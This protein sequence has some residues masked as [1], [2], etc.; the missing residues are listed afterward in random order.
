MGT[1]S[2]TE[3]E[4]REGSGGGLRRE[5][6]WQSVKGRDSGLGKCGMIVIKHSWP[7]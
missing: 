5:E 1:R 4:D 7:A 3:S 6:K 2:R